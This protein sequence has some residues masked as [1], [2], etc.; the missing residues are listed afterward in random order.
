MAVKQNLYDYCEKYGG[1][2]PEQIKKAK[3]YCGETGCSIIRS[4]LDT[5]AIKENKLL[6]VL[7]N[8]YNI[9]TTQ[10]LS[11]LEIDTDFVSKFNSSILIKNQAI[12]YSYDKKTVKVIISNPLTTIYAEDYIKEVVPQIS[13]FQYILTTEG[14]IESWFNNDNS[15]I[16]SRIVDISDVDIVESDSENKI[17][18]VSEN[19]IS[20][21]VNFVN[22]LFSDAYRKKASDIHIEPWS[23]S[24][25]IRLRID[26]ILNKYL[27]KPKNI[28]KQIINRIKTMSGMDVNNSRIPQDGA[29]RLKLSGKMIDMRVGAIPTIN[30]EKITLR[31]LDN[32]R[33]DFNIGMACFSE[34]NERKFREVIERPN[35]IVL[36][37]GPTGSGKSTVLYCAISELNKTEVCIITTENPV[38]YRIDGLV[39]IDV[40]DA[41]GL[42]FAAAIRQI[43]RQDPDIILVGEIR[44][45]ETARV[46]V[47]ASNT[48]HLVFSTLHTNSAAASVVRLIE[49]GVEPYMV[50]STLNAIVS[51]RLVRR[52]CSECKTEYKMP[53]NSQYR[54]LFD[55]PDNV[56][57]YKG[58]GC[59]KCNG[60]GYSGRIPVQE[61][62]VLDSE[63]RNMIN[64]NT[65]TAEIEKLAVKNGMKTIYDDGIDKAL[66]GFTTLDELHRVLHFENLY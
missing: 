29:I 7:G 3:A 32:S 50:A 52:I 9:P 46:A 44:D 57:L 59:P 13:K 42:G 37:T 40:N 41:I 43:L 38:E 26:G 63:I 10:T 56:K 30:G 33:T 4:L 18:D 22:N 39:Q 47:Q 36:I 61:L 62:L 45:E 5:A 24:M 20:S 55:N 64:A 60:T 2:T 31:L 21:I 28:H 65:T 6:E 25:V 11:N 16:G 48:G 19:D 23:D 15:M 35:G 27:Q 49:M 34:E 8:V 66:Q 17:Y 51:Q 12:P 54:K 1:V 58:K 14:E 53:P